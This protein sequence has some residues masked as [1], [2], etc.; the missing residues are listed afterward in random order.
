MTAL[1]AF[2]GGW[3]LLRRAGLKGRPSTAQGAALG[4]GVVENQALKGRDTLPVVPP[5]QGSIHFRALHPGLRPVLSNDAPLGLRPQPGGLQEIRRGLR[6]AATTPPD[7]DLNSFAPR[8]GARMRPDIAG[9]LAPFQGAESFGR[10]TGGIAVAQPPAN[11]WHGSAVRPRAARANLR[12]FF[13][14]HHLNLQD[15]V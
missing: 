4:S 11:F 12:K 10:L 14:P 9:L 2:I 15:S 6:S 3:E 7:R 5:F 8:R 13:S 1:A